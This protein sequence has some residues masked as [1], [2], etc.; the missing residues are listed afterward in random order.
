MREGFC[1]SKT[2]ARG[3]LP[4]DEIFSLTYKA[5]NAAAKRFDSAKGR[6][7]IFAKI[8]LRW[9]IKHA[10][11]EKSLVR[12]SQEQDA[13]LPE[14]DLGRETLHE[15]RSSHVAT[16]WLTPTNALDEIPAEASADFDF[17]K[18]EFNEQM[19]MLR[20]HILNLN[21]NERMVIDMRFR[22]GWDFAKIG[23]EI[24]R[25]RER[26]RQIALE[27]IRKLKEK[28]NP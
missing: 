9:E 15:E 18:V 11:A 21:E 27:A 16:D 17:E 25:S 26:V 12:N 2:C 6:F 14:Q 3:K 4:D 7:F 1:Y 10:W 20:P 22:T 23:R 24:G 19:N 28:V 5:L 8:Y 13:V